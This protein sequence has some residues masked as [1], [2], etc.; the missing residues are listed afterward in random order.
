[1]FK[2]V[3]K[4]AGKIR[5]TERNIG[6]EPWRIRTDLQQLLDDAQ[7]W[8]QRG[9]YPPDE[10][11]VRFHHR[12]VAIHC[13]ANG[14]G[15]HARLAADLLAIALG[16]PAFTWGVGDLAPVGEVRS[17]YIVALK[18]A[19]QHDYSSLLGFARS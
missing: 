17:A 10:I 13:F 3:W 2:P 9:S 5:T 19:D 4:W 16:E 1:M 6:A 8:V 14:N 12:L 11:A 7:T 18:Q 15:R